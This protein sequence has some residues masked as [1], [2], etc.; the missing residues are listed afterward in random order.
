MYRH[1]AYGFLY[2]LG[3]FLFFLLP[4]SAFAACAGIPSNGS[5]TLTNCIHT[6]AGTTGIDQAN[7]NELSTTN[8]AILTLNTGVS[9]TIN[10]GGTLVAGSVKPNGG[11]IAIESGGKILPGNPLYTI[12]AD[13]DGWSSTTPPTLYVATASGRRRLSLMRSLTT[14]DCQ[15]SSFSLTNQ[16]CTS[17][18]RYQDLDNDG[19]GNPNVSI[20]ACVTA[21]YVDNNTDCYDTNANAY[22][23]SS[24]CGT[25]SRGDG[26]FDYNC[27]STETTCGT[28]QNYSCTS[29]QLPNEYCS[30]NTCSSNTV[31]AYSSNTV[32][33]GAIGCTCTATAS[34][35]TNCSATGGMYPTCDIVSTASYCNAVTSGVQA[36][37]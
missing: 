24:Y 1:A 11:T 13:T 37:R 3:L 27:S 17:V 16:C 18:L 31:T 30:G 19:Y 4:A 26:S 23:S 9:I 15:D 12:D 2:L 14:A 33:C 25:T 6:V 32:L 34:R 8:T 7:N 21:G 29:A 36:C 28:A 5:V 22:P 20:V 35:G 10:A